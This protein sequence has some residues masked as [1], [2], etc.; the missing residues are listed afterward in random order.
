MKLSKPK[1]L[2]LS[3]LIVC[4]AVTSTFAAKYF[5]SKHQNAFE[6]NKKTMM[7]SKNSRGGSGRQ[8]HK[9]RNVDPNCCTDPNCCINPNC[10][11]S[12]KGLVSDET[13]TQAQANIVKNAIIASKDPNKSMKNILDPLVTAGTLTQAQ[14][15]AVLKICP[16]NCN[17]HSDPRG[18]GNQVRKNPMQDLIS[19]GTI[20]QAQANAIRSSIQQFIG[21]KNFMK[22][23]ID[24]LVTAGTLTQAQENA[25]L[26]QI[27][28]NNAK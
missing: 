1:V 5:S 12:I 26:N 2:A 24:P 21:S 10:A 11:N 20:T 27:L 23:A 8:N 13:I 28:Q 22:E 6:H 19:T 3:A 7:F 17:A 25:V 15:N 18:K 16:Q 4:L 14:E 9:K